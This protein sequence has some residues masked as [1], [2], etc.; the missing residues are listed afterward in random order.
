MDL[1]S[2]ILSTSTRVVLVYINNAKTPVI[3]ACV[4]YYYVITFSYP[5]M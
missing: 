3:A 2:A 1:Y 4:Y 5:V